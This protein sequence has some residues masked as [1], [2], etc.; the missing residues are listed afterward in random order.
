MGFKDVWL[1]PLEL[2]RKLKE[3]L[4]LTEGKSRIRSRHTGRSV[5]AGGT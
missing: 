4:A 2:E 5:E 1:F 3:A